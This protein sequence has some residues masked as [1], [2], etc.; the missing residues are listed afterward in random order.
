LDCRE[1]ALLRLLPSAVSK[2]L[3]VGDCWIGATTDASGTPH[4]VANGLCIERKAVADLEGSILD[5]RYREQR[6][7]LLAATG[8]AKAHPVYL[9]E[10]SLDRL[11]AVRLSE[12][13]LLKHL[14]RLQ[15]RYHIAVFRTESTQET[16]ALLQ[17]LEEQ[18]TEDPTTFEMPATIS[19]VE[20]MGQSKAAN[21][22]D[23][24][25]FAI[26]VLTGC[27]GISAVIAGQI[28]A[29]CG[30]T[31]EGVWA[32]TAAQFAAVVSGKR[33]L[34]AVK[35][36]RLYALLHGPLSELKLTYGIPCS[37]HRRA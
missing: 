20:S 18:W 1:H 11:G 30:G 27:R 21:R 23:P 36:G 15:L 31:L 16:A 37:R 5:G 17:L 4:L 33:A 12:R 14:T 9:I 3:M 8:E 2:Q 29:A 35:G 22:D 32:A 25:S 26:H 19:Y 6:T 7:R 28:L 24:A 13:A 10:G 34:G